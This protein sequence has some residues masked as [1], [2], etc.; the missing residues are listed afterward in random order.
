[1]QR[2]FPWPARRHLVAGPGRFASSREPDEI[3]NVDNRE[4]PSGMFGLV[5]ARVMEVAAVMKGHPARGHLHRDGFGHLVP[6]LR[7]LVHDAL[8]GYTQRDRFL[9]AQFVR[10]RHKVK[11]SV[12]DR[13][14][15]HS[16]PGRQRAVRLHGPVGQ[17]L[18]PVG[19]AAA[20]PAGFDHGVVVIDTYVTAAREAPRGFGQRVG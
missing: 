13:Y 9:R 2:M 4:R 16:Y 3:G 11:A 14:V 10:A 6:P 20:G 15:I 1:M 7:H 19:R 8:T 5:G 17:I 18:V 12:F